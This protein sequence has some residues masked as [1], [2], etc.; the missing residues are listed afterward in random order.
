[1]IFSKEKNLFLEFNGE[2]GKVSYD[3]YELNG[4]NL[5]AR[6]KDNIFEIKN[7]NNQLLDISG[8]INLNNETINLNTKIQDLS[9]KK[10]KIE[11]PEIRINDVIGKIE[12]KLSNPKGKLFLNDIEI[13]L[14]NNEK[15][16][17]NGELGYS[18]NNLFIKQLKVNNN[19]IKGNYS[20]KDNSYNAT[21]NLI[22]E[23]IG[24]Y[25]GNSSLKY[26]VIGTAK[27]RG[28]EKNIQH[29]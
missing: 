29:L 17:V 6:L 28:K 20:L 25:Y 21:I 23:N 19:I 3:D 24:R 26:R 27:I 5:V 2:I 22:E 16:G 13:I 12:G 8:N 9:L 18:N 10:F 7:F 14:E 11:K 15:I 4:L 1:M